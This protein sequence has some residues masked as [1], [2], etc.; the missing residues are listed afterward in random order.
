MFRRLKQKLRQRLQAY[1]RKEG[2][3]VS[4]DIDLRRLQ[5][6]DAES[7]A[8]I[9]RCMPMA[10]SYADKFGLLQASIAQVEVSGLY[11]ECGFYR[12]E[13][14]NF[15]ASLVPAEIHGFDSFEGL[16]EN[17]RVCHPTGAFALFQLPHVRS[18]VR[19][20]RG[21]FEDSIL[22]FKQKHAAPV[23]FLHLDAALY[24]STRTVLELLA[25][26]IVAGTVLQ[27][28]E[29]FNY[30]GW[31]D[32]EYKAFVEFCSKRGAEPRY[33]GYTSCDEQVAVKIANI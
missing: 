1:L 12:G 7:A 28:D 10:Q 33:L 23:A 11:C 14:I 6:A 3:E 2:A 25:D 29:F 8:F 17:W 27:F 22:D 32:G 5:K 4:R 30:P 13:T 31:Q 9:D 18:N 21:W 26:R 15:I 19:L 20:H 16:P 24:T